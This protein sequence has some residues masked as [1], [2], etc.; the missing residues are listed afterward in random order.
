MKKILVISM[1][2]VISISI[3]TGCG[4]KKEGQIKQEQEQGKVNV[5]TKE[6]VV[7]DKQV[8]VFKF[9]KTSLTY[10]NKVTR[11]QTRVTNTS[12]EEQTLIQFRVHFIKD[13]KEIINLPGYVGKTLKP[14]ETKILT[15]TYGGDI[16]DITRIEYEIIK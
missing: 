2:T 8:E 3:I 6:E 4:K 10:D 13:E 12:E 14:K 1:I 7:G 5:N 16:T 15:T 11:L 9:E